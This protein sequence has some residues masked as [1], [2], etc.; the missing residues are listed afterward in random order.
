VKAFSSAGIPSTGARGSASDNGTVPQRQQHSSASAKLDRHTSV[1]GSAVTTFTDAYEFQRTLRGTELRA[2]VNMP[3]AYQ[4]EL[5]RIDLHRLWMQHSQQ[6]LAQVVHFATPKDRVGIHLL[7]D[8]DHA[9]VFLDGKEVSA[10]D[11]ICYRPGAEHHFRTTAESR[12]LSMSLPIPDLAEAGLAITGGELAAVAATRLIRLPVQL[13]SRLRNLLQSADHLAHSAPGI[14]AHREVARAIE[15][16][17]AH[18]MVHCLTEGATVTAAAPADT[19]VAVMRRFERAL[20]ENAGRPVYL[21]EICA[22][23]GVSDRT[24]RR[25]CLEQ[26]GMSPHQYLWLRRMHLARR[27]LALAD[28]TG[29]TVAAIANDH[30]FPELGRFAVSY[31]R[32]FGESPSVTL[33]RAPDLPAPLRT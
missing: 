31:R 32:L 12:W 2:V 8:P 30:G 28:A 21:S 14:L 4:A 26:L 25:H 9:S 3:G 18:A 17:L 24:L 1:P 29:T 7:A 33:R 23:I 13:M 19:R 10:D 15:Q 22:A 11:L 5:T 27:S 20:A 16:E 6:S